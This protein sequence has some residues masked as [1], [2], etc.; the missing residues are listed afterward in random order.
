MWASSPPSTMC[1]CV[2]VYQKKRKTCLP[3][4]YELMNLCM[5]MCDNKFSNILKAVILHETS[6]VYACF[7][8]TNAHERLN[9]PLAH[10]WT[11]SGYHLQAIS[12]AIPS[13]R[14]LFLLLPAR[15]FPS[16]IWHRSHNK[17]PC[18]SAPWKEMQLLNWREE[19]EEEGGRKGREEGKGK[20][21]GRGGIEIAKTS[22]TSWKIASPLDGTSQATIK[23]CQD[24]AIVAN[25]VSIY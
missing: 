15:L 11:Q 8:H 6:E 21:G 23:R 24:A 20:E 7:A 5:C 19:E 12:Q 18:I 13:K 9:L 1:V 3:A 17:Q 10:T 2:C 4:L 25:Q 16:K 22:V 14:R